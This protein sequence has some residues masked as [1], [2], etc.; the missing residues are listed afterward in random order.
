MCKTALPYPERLCAVGW[1]GTNGMLRRIA[2][3]HALADLFARITVLLH[4]DCR[5]CRRTFMII[6]E[7]R[8]SI[9]HQSLR[10]D[11]RVQALKTLPLQI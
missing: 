1:P 10:F 4:S 3:V 2:N 9:L 8:H 5:K 11:E 6:K 7:V